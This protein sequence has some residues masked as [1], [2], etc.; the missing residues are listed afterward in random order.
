LLGLA[1]TRFTSRSDLQKSL[2]LSPE[3]KLITL[4]SHT[5]ISYLVLLRIYPSIVTVTLSLHKVTRTTKSIIIIQFTCLVD[6]IVVGTFTRLIYL[7]KTG[8]DAVV[9]AWD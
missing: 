8:S 1:G 7:T 9:K 4:I 2:F 6:I 3:I 5:S